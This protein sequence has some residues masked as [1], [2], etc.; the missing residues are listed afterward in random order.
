MCKFCGAVL[1]LGEDQR[2]KSG[3]KSQC[4]SN[5]ECNTEEMK[6][7]FE[8]LQNPPAEF[9][10]NLVQA[11]NEKVREA[12]LSTTMPLNNSFAFA[13]IRHGDPC[14]EDQMGGRLD[15]CKYNGAFYNFVKPF[16]HKKD[17]FVCFQ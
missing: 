13:S 8:E 11:K 4:C 7:E 16:Q 2:I 15:T 5:G 6:K 14:P 10:E 9:I 3:H 17:F 1:L 12:F